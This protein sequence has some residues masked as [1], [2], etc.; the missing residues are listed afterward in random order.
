[1]HALVAIATERP[2][3]SSKRPGVRSVEC[4]LTAASGLASSDVARLSTAV[5][6][7]CSDIAIN[8]SRYARARAP[9][10]RRHAVTRNDPPQVRKA[11]WHETQPYQCV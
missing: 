8:A 9:P 11:L 4:P 10:E 3:I 1:V 7:T 2:D 6:T 5:S